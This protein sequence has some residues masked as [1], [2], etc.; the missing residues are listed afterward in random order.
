MLRFTRAVC[1]NFRLQAA[2]KVNKRKRLTDKLV[3]PTGSWLMPL[4]LCSVLSQSAPSSLRLW[5]LRMTVDAVSCP[6]STTAFHL[7]M[8]ILSAQGCV[9]GDPQ[10][11]CLLTI[12]VLAMWSVELWWDLTHLRIGASFS[13]SWTSRRNWDILVQRTGW[14]GELV[15]GLMVWIFAISLAISLHIHTK[16]RKKQ[17]L[18]HFLKKWRL[19]QTMYTLRN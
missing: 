19:V 2:A 12:N 5:P 18:F 8:T 3:R 15:L 17:T 7:Q 13:A 6:T 10:H 9:F 1:L 14:G 16:D 4:G 11:Q